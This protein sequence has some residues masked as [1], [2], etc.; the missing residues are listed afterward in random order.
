MVIKEK[1]PPKVMSFK[2]QA[3]GLLTGPTVAPYGAIPPAGL[4]YP[5][6]Y[7]VPSVQPYG[8]VERPWVP[9]PK[10]DYSNVGLFFG[11]RLGAAIPVGGLSDASATGVGGDLEAYFRFAHKWFVGVYG[12][13]D[14]YRKASTADGTSSAANDVGAAIGFTTNPEGVGFMMDLTLGYRWYNANP[15]DGSSVTL[16][17][18]E[19]GLGMGLWIAIG[20][21][22]RLVPRIDL[23]AGSLSSSASGGITPTPLIND[24][25]GYAVFFAGVS[26]YFN[27]DFGRPK[28][29]GPAPAPL[30]APEAPP[31]TAPTAP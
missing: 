3:N 4:L 12:G 7:A 1:E 24:T 11:A 19:G 31:A 18:A 25:G 29:A 13:H 16:Q 17:G 14:F 23:S 27:I 26:G 21:S 2:L 15:T 28:T 10:K 5:Q 6:P 22:F 20:K 8:V 9:P 30:P